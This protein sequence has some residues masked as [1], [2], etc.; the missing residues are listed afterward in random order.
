MSHVQSG[1]EKCNQVQPLWFLRCYCHLR[2]FSFLISHIAKFIF[3]ASGMIRDWL[4]LGPIW[5]LFSIWTLLPKPIVKFTTNHRFDWIFYLA[6]P[7]K[8][9]SC[10]FLCIHCHI[11]YWRCKPNVQ[12]SVNGP[13]INTETDFNLDFLSR[14]AGVVIIVISWHSTIDK[15]QQESVGGH[16]D[17]IWNKQ[18]CKCP[19]LCS[20]RGLGHIYRQATNRVDQNKF[21][22]A[23]GNINIPCAPDD[24]YTTCCFVSMHALLW[25]D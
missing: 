11:F 18:K 10:Q 22:P 15:S 9:T 12:H 24:K 2:R 1:T 3:L 13:V 19:D 20:T 23:I 17:W 8:L 7:F 4:Q 21:K 25:F 5:H 14:K 6:W 16:L